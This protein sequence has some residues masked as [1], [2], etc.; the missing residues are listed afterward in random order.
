MEIRS[1]STAWLDQ[2]RKRT[3]YEEA[4]VV[5]YWLAD[6]A[7]PSLTM[8]E[9]VDGCYVQVAHAIGDQTMHLTTPI[10]IT[11]NPAVLARR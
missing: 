5:S 8:L 11:L 7:T 9:L 2:G 3:L 10:S 1:A 4:G 6:P